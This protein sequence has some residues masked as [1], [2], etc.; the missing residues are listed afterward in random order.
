[1]NKKTVAV[2]FGSRS[3]EHD[4]SVVS[5]SNVIA[6]INTDIYEVVIIGIT[7]DGKWLKVNDINDMKTGNWLN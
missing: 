4:V 1:M 7:K 5:A 3:S 2:L 6:N